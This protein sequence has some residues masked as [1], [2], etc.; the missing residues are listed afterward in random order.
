MKIALCGSMS[1]AKEIL[2]IKEKLEKKKHDVI[3][4]ANVE[5]YANGTIVV[6][7]KWKK[8]ESDVIKS[9]FEKIK[10]VDAILVV[11]KDKNEIKNYIGGNGLIEMAFA[12]VLGKKIYLFN[13]IPKTN[14]SDEIKAMKPSIIKGDLDKVG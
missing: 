10:T 12:H 4:P 7:D 11:N 1:V 13:E 9:Y 14:Y 6:E 5:S 2:E 3:V 8:I